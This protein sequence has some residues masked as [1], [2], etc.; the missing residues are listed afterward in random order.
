MK[1]KNQIINFLIL[2]LFIS[3]CSSSKLENSTTT[4]PDVLNHFKANGYVGEY[5]LKFFS[6]VGAIG[7]GSYIGDNFSF[8]IY[9]F[10]S[11]SKTKNMAA[12][13][14]CYQKG[15]FVIMVHRGNI[16]KI[17]EVFQRF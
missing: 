2:L 13:K 14:N 6:L 12:Y 7:G 8:E 9:Q 4:I 1:T 16:E 17:N 3:G 11:P 15:Y 5:D 10:D